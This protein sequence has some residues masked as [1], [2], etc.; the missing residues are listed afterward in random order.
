MSSLWIKIEFNKSLQGYLRYILV[1]WFKLPMVKY[2]GQSAKSLAIMLNYVL[3]LANKTRIMVVLLIPSFVIK[4]WLFHHQF[5]VF[6]SPY[7]LS[8][9]SLKFRF[10]GKFEVYWWMRLY[11][12]FCSNSL[13]PIKNRNN[14]IILY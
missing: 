4:S 10:H 1:S 7:N 11:T 9:S 14:L 12:R 6:I 13:Y 8:S 3:S 5:P 2:T